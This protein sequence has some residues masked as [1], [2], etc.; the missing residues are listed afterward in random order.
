MSHRLTSKEI[1]ILGF[2]TF[3]LFVGA[4]NI[5][6]PPIV[7]LQSGE[8][9][10][11]AAIGFLIT[12]VGLP[13]ITVIAL[14]RVGGNI[15]LLSA[16][17]GRSTGLLM[18]IVCY[19][20][21][22]PLF[23]I[24]RT[25][26]V[27]FELGIAPI[28]NYKNTALLVYSLIYFMLVISISLYPNRLVDTIGH[29]LAPLKIIALSILSIAAL[30]WPAGA[31]IPA[32]NNYQTMAFSSGFMNGYLTMDTLGAIVFSIVIVNSARSRGIQDSGLLTR[33]TI[34]ASLIAGIGLT[35]IYLSLF[36]LGTGSGILAPHAKNGAEVLHA[37][38]QNTFGNLGSVFLASLIF[39]SCMV[40]AIGLTCACAEFFSK[41]VPFSYKTIVFILGLFSITIS[42][43]GLS[44]LVQIS[45]P[46]LTAIYP[47]CIV[48]VLL[49]FTVSYWNNVRRIFAINMSI[50]LLFGILDAMKI[51]P[52]QQYIPTWINHLPLAEQGLS[53][54]PP[55]LLVLV[56]IAIYDQMCSTRNKITHC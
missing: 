15:D 22:G 50:S 56:L 29:V 7:G 14:A 36:K 48:M 34:L 39:V 2:M 55:T 51:S 37:Y 6:F 19:L 24:P 38:V 4:G 17:I 40:T 47:P 8:Y 25:A 46:V 9:V 20:T 49:S 26:T 3:A 18:A 44:Y 35:L 31:P 52:M 45:I 12:S 5:I 53:W 13:V 43:L 1:L 30:L 42:N 33:Y 21:V 28:I 10:W 11:N 32:I 41:H 27:S 23:A 16:P 54:L